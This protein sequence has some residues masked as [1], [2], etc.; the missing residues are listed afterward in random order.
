MLVRFTK[1]TPTHHTFSIIRADG[2]AEQASLET[3]SYMPHDLIHFAYELQA[4]CRYSF[5]GRLASGL[6]LADFNVIQLMTSPDPA[7]A[8]LITTERITGPLATYLKGGVTNA[9][10]I[11][12]LE[13]LFVAVSS[14]LPAH[15]TS[16]FLDELKI[17]YNALIGQW[18]ALPHHTPMEI[19][20]PL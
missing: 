6:K 15:I 2:S 12:A 5:Y 8:E 1:N 10:F 4:G 13:N 7:D 18:N 16:Q 17:R 20:W 19:S 11:S 9:D 3:R 14:P